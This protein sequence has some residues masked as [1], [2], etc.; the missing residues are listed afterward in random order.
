MAQSAIQII[1][2]IYLVYLGA[3][4]FKSSSSQ[5][6]SEQDTARPHTV[7]R[8]FLEGLSV[9]LLNVKATLF[10]LALFSGVIADSTPMLTKWIYCAY[11]SLATFAWF[12]LISM[13]LDRHS[14]KLLYLKNAPL[15]NR[16]F[17]IILIAL[18]ILWCVDS[19]YTL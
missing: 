6:E 4:A 11:L 12:A 14:I 9:N 2:S 7:T 1:G 8:T 15:I 19:L 18:G 3:D 5:N 13:L 16:V 10:F 17:G